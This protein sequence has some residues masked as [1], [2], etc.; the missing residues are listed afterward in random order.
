M[1]YAYALN[2]P[3]SKRSLCGKMALM[4]DERSIFSL[5]KSDR[6]LG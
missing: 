6:S 1:G 3:S 2:F 5:Q 4:K